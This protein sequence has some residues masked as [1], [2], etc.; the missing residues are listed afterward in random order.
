EGELAVA[1]ALVELDLVLLAEDL[2]ARGVDD[3]D[4]R[5]EVGVALAIE[6]DGERLAA[7]ILRARAGIGH[8]QGRAHLLFFGLFLGLGLF[9][10]AVGVGRVGLLLGGRILLLQVV[11]VVRIDVLLFLS[12]RHVPLHLLLSANREKS[13][14]DKTVAM[15]RRA[16][17]VA[18]IVTILAAAPL[19]VASASVTTAGVRGGEISGLGW[20]PTHATTVWAA[21][22]GAGLYK[23][24]NGGGAWSEILLPTITPHVVNKVLPS[25]AAADLLLVCEVA[26]SLD[27][28]WRSANGGTSFAGV[29]PTSTGSCTAL[30]DGTA[31]NTMYAG[32]Q[33][34]NNAAHVYKS[35]DA[36]QSWT[37]LGLN[38]PGVLVT[39]IVKLA[40]GRLVIGTADGAGGVRGNKNSGSL[41]YS[42]D[43][44]A[45][46]TAGTGIGNGAIAGIATNGGTTIIA[47][48]TGVNATL[49]TTSDGAAWSAGASFTGTAP[50][51]QIAYHAGSDTF[52]LMPAN[53]QLLQS[54]A[55]ASGGY[56]FGSAINRTASL[57]APVAFSVGHHTAFA[58]DPADATHLLVGDVAGGEGIFASADGGGTWAVANDGL[59]AQQVDFA[60]KTTKSGY[61]YAANR[62][63]FVYFGGTSLTA[64]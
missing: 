35:V 26:P 43:E 64:P 34:G 29:L 38:L 27:G 41:F 21:V 16:V 22:H 5:G 30:V 55:A 7:G 33:D 45:H 19:A 12:D 17:S 48:A 36:G 32:I 6:I 23:S 63:G 39:D 25:K 47:L 53:D 3:G 52:F 59:F 44:G 8:G 28:I 42:D 1:F 15:T 51:A 46:W 11:V 57:S 54:T 4:V 10:A 58:V 50:N 20:D 49:Y 24:T 37:L 40:S 9:V 61:R 14:C 62:T 18:A 31:A 60:F 13:C 2:L 56:T